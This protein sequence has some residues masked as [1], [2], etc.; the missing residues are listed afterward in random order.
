MTT[1][2]SDSEDERKLRD[3]PNR[4]K[5][6]ANGNHHTKNL[7]DSEF[8]QARQTR[9]QMPH[10]NTKLPASLRHLLRLVVNLFYTLGWVLVFLTWFPGGG[11]PGFDIGTVHLVNLDSDHYWFS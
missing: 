8:P 6:Q 9:Q 3:A 7:F 11:S 2:K 4:M 1:H 5:S 10:H